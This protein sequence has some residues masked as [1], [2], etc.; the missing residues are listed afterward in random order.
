MVLSK[1]LKVISFFVVLLSISVIVIER[2]LPEQKDCQNVD[3][4]PQ[5]LASWFRRGKYFNVFGHRVFAIWESDSYDGK[6]L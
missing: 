4:L 2:Y 3:D 5:E 1:S 6:L